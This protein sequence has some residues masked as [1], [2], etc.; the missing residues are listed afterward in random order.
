MFEERAEEILRRC[1]PYFIIKRGQADIALAYRMLKRQ[2]SRGRKVT[3]EVWQEREN[4]KQDISALNAT[5]RSAQE[6]VN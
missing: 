6:K 4:H 2:G 5:P 3:Q 1:L